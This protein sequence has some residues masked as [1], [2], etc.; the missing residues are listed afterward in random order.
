MKDRATTARPA[1]PTDIEALITAAKKGKPFEATGTTRPIFDAEI[2]RTLVLGVHAPNGVQISSVAIE[3]LLNLSNARGSG[4]ACNALIL[5]DCDLLGDGDVSGVKPGIDASHSHLQRLSLVKCRADGVELSGATIVGD[6]DL[7]GFGPRQL[8]ASG[9]PLE[10]QLGERRAAWVK[11]RGIRIGGS[12]TARK[13]TLSVPWQRGAE[14]PPKG[15]QGWANVPAPFGLDLDGAQISGSLILQPGFESIGGVNIA[16]AMIGGDLWAQGAHLEAAGVGRES[17]EALRAQSVEIHGHAVF[18]CDTDSIDDGRSDP[19]RRFDARGTL[20]FYGAKI[21]GTFVLYGARVTGAEDDENPA[22]YLY[23]ASLSADVLIGRDDRAEGVPCDI[24]T[25]DLTTATIGGQLLLQGSDGTPMASVAATGLRVSG[26]LTLSGPMSQVDLSGS[27]VEGQLSLGRYDP[28]KLTRDAVVTL[29][30]ARV[31]RDLRADW[32]STPSFPVKIEWSKT[33]P[34]RIR[35]IP[36]ASYPGWWLAEALVEPTVGS[37]LAILS[38]LCRPGE[39]WETVEEVVILDGGSEPIHTLNGRELL[40]LDTIEQAKEYLALFCAHIWVGDRAFMVDR[41]SVDLRQ[42]EGGPRWE[43][44]GE[45][46]HGPDL[47]EARFRIEASGEVVMSNDE[48]IGHVCDDTGRLHR[49]PVRWFHAFLGQ[50]DWP[51]PPPLRPES[52]WYEIADPN[53]HVIWDALKAA[54]ERLEDIHLEWDEEWKRPTIDL[55]GLKVASLADNDGRNWFDVTPNVVA[56]SRPRPTLYLVL[57][58]FEYDRI[59]DKPPPEEERKPRT[60]ASLSFNEPSPTDSDG[61]YAAALRDQPRPR[62]TRAVARRLLSLLRLLHPRSLAASLNATFLSLVRPHPSPEHLARRYWLRAQYAKYPPA[63]EYPPAEDRY[64]P[65]PYQQLAKVLR[66]AGYLTAADDV[67]IDKLELEKVKLLKPDLP[68]AR[69]AL[70]RTMQWATRW[71]VQFPFGFGLKPWRA[72]ATFFLFW[73]VGVLAIWGLSQADVLKVDASAV[74]T[75]VSSDGER[76]R[77]VVEEVEGVAEPLEEIPCRNLINVVVYPLDVMIP[78][79]DLRQESRCHV[80]FQNQ[81]LEVL[82][83]IYAILGWLIISGLIVTW[84]GIVRRQTEG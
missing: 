60:D 9:A 7:E 38:F 78:L 24:S 45:V 19:R 34:L 27:L 35:A 47:F 41:E 80:S 79:L 67:T 36:L 64:R 3:G 22:I 11:A 42:P 20:D 5:T 82:K 13:T 29:A 33:R 17:I 30:D 26:D 44:V 56:E 54:T 43:A 73:A 6:L 83:G 2:I 57:S 40:A 61:P 28:L 74:A 31:G 62:K 58:G 70:H 59:S 77:V 52:S 23:S 65:Q 76:E 51:A 4:E 14:W 46:A 18:S 69:Q 49:T 39:S 75:V 25:I 12:M 71:L 10:A 37:G 68:P 1:T 16:G 72:T 32:I 50:E 63:E 15:V 21:R 81:G 84:S 48:W 66:G 8:D 53:D 55:A